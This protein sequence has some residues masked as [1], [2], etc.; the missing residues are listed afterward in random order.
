V[1]LKLDSRV[2]VDKLDRLGDLP[3]MLG[4]ERVTSATRS[5]LN[6]YIYICI[7]NMYY[8]STIYYIEG[9]G[10]IPNKGDLRGL[11]VL[12]ILDELLQNCDIHHVVFKNALV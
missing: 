11:S 9:V 12:S 4:L 1:S 5:P 2:L 7:S 10:P 3:D 6:I 8:I